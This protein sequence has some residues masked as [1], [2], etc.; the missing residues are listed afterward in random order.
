ME[1][2]I[3]RS[4][5]TSSV[6]LPIELLRA[7]AVLSAKRNL[8]KMVSSKPITYIPLAVVELADVHVRTDGQKRGKWYSNR[9]VF[10]L[11]RA[12]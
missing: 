11:D 8:E 10:E 12:S 5:Y 3:T 7:H 6:L 9:S 2:G 4:L 1:T